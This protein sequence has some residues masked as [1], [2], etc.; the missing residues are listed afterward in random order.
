MPT[1]THALIIFDCDGVQVDSEPIANRILSTFLN[2]EGYQCSFA[3]SVKKFVGKDLP[4]ILRQVECELGRHLSEGFMQRLRTETYKAFKEH[5]RPVDGIEMVL[6]QI[7]APKCV[8]SSGNME[9]MDL[10]LNLTGLRHHF[11]DAIFSA[12]QVPQG[13]PHPDLF[14]H[15]ARHFG[16]SPHLCTVIEDSVPGV[17]GARAAGMTVLGYAGGKYIPPRHDQSLSE[18]GA[19]VFFTMRA[20]PGLLGI[21]PL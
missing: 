12:H 9:K 8:A 3:E 5:L 6:D 20:L 18:A 1:A 2:K 21:K 17:V 11:G 16:V 10:T 7:L 19:Q 14:L 4:S 13:K 15:A